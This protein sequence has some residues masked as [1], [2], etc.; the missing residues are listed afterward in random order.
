MNPGDKNTIKHDPIVMPNYISWNKGELFDY[1]EHLKVE[2][3]KELE[4]NTGKAS[5]AN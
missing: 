4:R 3:Q 5:T 1:D 2:S